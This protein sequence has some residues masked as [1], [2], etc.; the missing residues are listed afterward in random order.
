EA[1]Y[2]REWIE[3]HRLVGVERFFLYDH[4]SVDDSR[5]VL[6]PYIE[7][8]TV[9]LHHW[10]VHP[11]QL[12]A[13]DD[14]LERHRSD[15]RWIAFIDLDE[16][17]FSGSGRPVSEILRDFEDFPGVVVNE[18]HFYTSGH[19]QRPPGL[20]IENYLTR[21]LNPEMWVK[22]IVDPART[23]RTINAHLFKYD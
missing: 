14:C 7:D 15:S 5:E 6:A 18:A 10:P 4:E 13:I 1:S 20:V 21:D 16:F 9:V 23:L 11:G 2:L 12:E 8:G 3:F 17:L 22:S 19:R